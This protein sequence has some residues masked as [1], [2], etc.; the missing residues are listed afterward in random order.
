MARADGYARRR[1]EDAVLHGVLRELDA[2]LEGG[3]LEHGLVHP[4][5]FQRWTDMLVTSLRGEIDAEEPDGAAE[6]PA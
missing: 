4:A 3:L 2:Y 1:P 5:S 6:G